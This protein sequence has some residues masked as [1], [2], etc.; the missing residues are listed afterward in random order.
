MADGLSFSLWLVTAVTVLATIAAALMFRWARGQ[1]ERP[2]DAIQRDPAAKE[3]G[4][5]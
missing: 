1:D 4:P 3:S 2:E 5:A